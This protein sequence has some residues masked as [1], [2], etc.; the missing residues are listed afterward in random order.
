MKSLFVTSEA[1]PYISSGSLGQV[2]CLLPF[3]LRQRLIGCRVVMPLYDEISQELKDNMKFVTSLSVPVSWRRQY[4][5]VFESR[6]N[7]VIY[8]FIDNR[9]YF[10]RS[11]LY[12]HY[13]DAERFAFFSRA[14]LEMLP[15]IDFKP[16]I[17]HSNDWQTALVPVYYSIFYSKIDWYK[18]IKTIFTIHNIQIQGKYTQE[19]LD[20]VVGVPHESIPILEYDGKINFMKSA[21]ETAHKVTTVS[22]QYALE[23]QNPYF[24]YGLDK[25]LSQ[26]SWKLSGILNGISTNLYNPNDDKYIYQNFSDEDL[27][28][29]KECKRLL[30]KDLNLNVSDNVPLLAI[31]SKMTTQKGMA[32]IKET[33]DQVLIE[34]DIQVVV[35]GSGEWEYESFF[36]EIGGRYKGKISVN[37]GFNDSL[38]HKVYA[39][40]DILLM[41]SQTEP[42]GKSQMVAM[43]YG[44]IPIVHEIGGLKDTVK[45][46]GDL[47]GNGFTFQTYS[48]IDMMDCINRVITGYKNR[49]RWE[50]LVKRAMNCDFSWG[51]SANEYIKLYK[52]LSNN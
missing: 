38:I 51:R 11:G 49:D 16:D 39:G 36:K 18:D 30:Q 29:K 9:Y 1:D 43:R 15:Y 12:G 33:L 52:E 20:E 8:Y 28:G 7:G 6:C 46:S 25:I 13:D 40:S 45:D 47:L 32:L 27:N 3:S 35:V 22:P 37:M 14:V 10:K 31:I 4:C 42:C 41:P 5:G 26:R 48:P 50:N 23:I 2:S 17:I 34:Q 44:T 24:S 21:I 19:I